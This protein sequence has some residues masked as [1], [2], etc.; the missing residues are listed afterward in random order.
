[1][2][3]ELKIKISTTADVSAIQAT[4]K[5][6]EGVEKVSMPASAGIKKFGDEVDSA[7]R[8][9]SGFSSSINDSIS[10]VKNLVLGY[11]ALNSLMSGSKAFIE[12][13]DSMNNLNGRLKLA[14]SSTAEFASQQKEL[15]GVALQTHNP[16]KN[17]TDLYI[18]LDPALKAMGATTVTVNKVTEDFAKGL[19]LGGASVAE[20]AAASLQFGQAMGSGVL[21]GDEFNSMMEAS[22]KLM[23]YMAKGMNVPIGALRAMAENGELTS[24]K[25]SAALLKMSGDIDRDFKQ[26]PQTVGNSMVD[27]R[28]NLG[29][30]VE[31]IDKATGVTSFLSST[32]TDLSKSLSGSTESFVNALPVI[33]GIATATIVMGTAV[34][35]AAG[36]EAL[37]AISLTASTEAMA[38]ASATTAVHTAMEA[39][40]AEAVTLGAYAV[41]ARS[42][43]DRAN[44]TGIINNTIATTAQ[45]AALN[46]EATSAEAAA[47]AQ[48]GHA[49]ALREA[50]ISAVGASA[51]V[52]LMGMAMKAVPFV[53]VASTVALL[54]SSFF[55]AKKDSDELNNSLTQTTDTLAK[56]TKN[57][58]EY[59][60]ITLA[61]SVTDLGLELRQAK[62]SAQVQG[63]F[64]SDDDYAKEKSDLDELKQKY[65]DTLKASRQVNEFKPN[66]TMKPTD[67][68]TEAENLKAQIALLQNAP[69]TKTAAQLS[70]EAAALK[71]Q[72]TEAEKL[73]QSYLSINK[74][75]ADLTGND[76]DKAIASI[77]QKAETYRKGK[78]D[79]LKISELT[80]N[81]MIALYQKEQEEKNNLLIGHYQTIG[82]EDAAYYL[83]LS[84]DIDNMFKKGVASYSEINAFREDSD[85]KYTDKRLEQERSFY[86]SLNTL[87]GDWYTNESIKIGE[88]YSVYEKQ[89]RNR[90]EL[91]QWLNDSMRA[92]DKDR[93][94][95]KKTTV[96]SYEDQINKLSASTVLTFQPTGD[97]NVDA[98]SSM[99]NALSQVNKMY[100]DQMLTLREINKLKYQLTNDKELPE[101]EKARILKQIPEL[102]ARNAKLSLKHNI[103]A[104]A[105]AL[106]ASKLLVGE[107]SKAY[108]AISAMEKAAHIASLTMTAEQQAADLGKALTSAVA[109]VTASGSGDP[110]TAIPRVIG[111]TA[112]MASTLGHIGVSFCGGGG[113]SSGGSSASYT[114]P[115]AYSGTVLGDA[116]KVSESTTKIVDILGSIHISEYS[117]LRDINRAVTSMSENINS[118]ITNIFRTQGGF[119]ASSFTSQNENSIVSMTK[120][121]LNTAMD[122]ATNIANKLGGPLTQALVNSMNNSLGKVM[123]SIAS[124]AFGGG[125]ST[126]LESNKLVTGSNTVDSYL[127]G[128]S[129]GAYY[130]GLIHTHK[131]GGWFGSDSDSY[132]NLTQGVD[133][134]VQSSI[135]AI[136]RS[137]SDTL[138]AVSVG[139][140]QGT[141]AK[142]K[143]YQFGALSIETL[144]KTSEQIVTDMN[145]AISSMGDQMISGV[146]N[147]ILTQYQHLGEGLLET[148][149][150][151]V[152]EKEVVLQD[153][154]NVNKSIT[155]NVLDIT[156]SLVDLSG[157]LTKFSDA[158]SSYFDNYFSDAE[159]S[160]VY[161][162][163]L[164]S[165]YKSMNITMPTT[166]AGFRSTVDAL[167]LNTAS[168][169]DTYVS[170]MNIADAQKTYMDSLKA[171]TKLTAPKDMMLSRA[172]DATYIGGKTDG[173]VN[174]LQL[175]A[176]NNILREFQTQTRI[177]QLTGGIA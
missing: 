173:T 43:A 79:E 124:K 53:A 5:G 134:S 4:I 22:P 84:M 109:S 111:M 83:K 45:I 149:V 9:S 26:L 20:A 17:I 58:L 141:E 48:T 47:L 110:Y 120:S 35:L 169:R 95:K 131:D 152:V 46:V 166:I 125:T 18:K 164:E 168:G 29:L 119:S 59:R 8:A 60:K 102:E 98:F 51:S 28:T 99:I 117:Q 128:G 159:K 135:T 142:A 114:P 27:F 115:A 67:K 151:V 40:D 74:D 163:N 91:E 136:Y 21:R 133:A 78:V 6:L 2:P 148:A 143:A 13:A 81:G 104:A 145:N 139:V 161:Q 85:K 68:N 24:G 129:A 112:L 176:L 150:R 15:L 137:L 116:S 157:G 70:K 92:L 127:N 105:Q 158:N 146:F 57:Q 147:G 63:I 175:D 69:I 77:N 100:E 71:K 14:T 97:K 30:A 121:V 72:E 54:A 106:G 123:G 25:V 162:K 122:S 94:D 34:K 49:L 113:G 1:M 31:D 154:A 44:A 10:S 88:Q 172:N 126:S 165:A 64:Q 11:F 55:D 103:D 160:A 87:A 167:D 155:G 138:I 39:A 3:S 38:I 174:V 19:K 75:I 140:G 177:L 66:T 144:G 42:I 16:L 50:G 73:K 130:S 82:D 36:Y 170:L 61:S 76:H 156:Q 23:S 12:T 118:A 37:R 52:G 96:E 171:L 7:G 153:L 86:S 101:A 107:K 41:T 32:I 56:L 33:E 108:T 90:L 62:Q 89:G 80:S 93:F 65:N 132:R